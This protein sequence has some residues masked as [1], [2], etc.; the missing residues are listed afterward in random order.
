MT[1][2]RRKCLEMGCDDYLSKPIRREELLQVVKRH[3]QLATATEA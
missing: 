2:D 1:D 3:T